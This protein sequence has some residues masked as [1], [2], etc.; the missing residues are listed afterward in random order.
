[1]VVVAAADVDGWIRPIRKRIEIT[2]RSRTFTKRIGGV[3]AERSQSRLASWRLEKTRE[4][5]GPVYQNGSPHSGGD[6][7]LEARLA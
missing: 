1:M 6:K 7:A 5:E 4:R 3:I 2:I